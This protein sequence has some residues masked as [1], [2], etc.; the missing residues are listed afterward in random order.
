MAA[1]LDAVARVYGGDLSR[2]AEAAARAGKADAVAIGT[3]L[4]RMSR[5]GRR[6]VK[7]GAGY[8]VANGGRRVLVALRP[9]GA[10]IIAERG[11]TGHDIAPKRRTTK[12]GRQRTGPRVGWTVAGASWGHPVGVIHHPGARGRHGVTRAFASM[13]DTIPRAFHDGLVAE[14]RRIYG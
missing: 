13:R 8:D 7:L 9:P 12:A 5:M 2:P 14:L 11:A 10:W 6:G 4:G 3:A 1:R